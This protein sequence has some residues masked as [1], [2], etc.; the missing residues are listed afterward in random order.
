MAKQLQISAA[1]S[2]HHKTT[3]LTT[4]AIAIGWG[5]LLYN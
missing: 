4:G 2:R 1:T 3:A 5:Q